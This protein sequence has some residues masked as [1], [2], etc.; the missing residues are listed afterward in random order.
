M[1][2]AASI[3]DLG[4]QPLVKACG[5]LLFNSVLMLFL[6]GQALAQDVA[7]GCGALRVTGRFGPY[8]YRPDKYIPDSV[9]RSHQALLSIVESYHFT[10]EVEALVRGKTGPTAG[11][12]LSYTLHAFPNHHRAL[13]AM[14]ALGEKENTNRPRGSSYSVECWLKRA[15]AWRSDDNLVR[16]IYAQYLVKSK[17]ENEA[18]QQLSAAASQAGDNAFTQHNIGLIYFD[19]KNYQKALVHAHKAYALGLG[20]PTL[21][22]QLK[23]IGQWSEPADA[24]LVEPAKNPQ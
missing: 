2:L 3:K 7:G 19:M 9:H 20:I 21:K 10:P 13:I 6:S 17:R 14:V 11:G 4:N 15:V 22:E 24:Y 1:S 5:A 16:L 8:D 18:E 12:D 23:S